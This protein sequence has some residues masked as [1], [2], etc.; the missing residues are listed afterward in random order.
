MAMR[1]K[2]SAKA[3]ASLVSAQIARRREGR[4][5]MPLSADVRGSLPR[6]ST[7]Q[8]T[9]K[10]RNISSTGAYLYLQAA[11]IVGTKLT[12]AISL[13][14][15]ATGG[16]PLRLKIAGSVVRMEKAR[17]TSRKLGVAVRFA[18]EYRFVAAPTRS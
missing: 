4:F 8:E 16:K 7:F 17:K 13:P 3:A 12:L 15:R 9:A 1:T 6:G 10:I 18:R 2:S 11:V 5:E 14:A